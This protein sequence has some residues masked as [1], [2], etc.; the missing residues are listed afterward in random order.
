MTTTALP[1]LV[2][3]LSPGDTDTVHA[4]FAQL[5]PTSVWLRFHTGMPRL[6]P[7]MAARLA[8]VSPGRHE[9]MVAR[10]EGRP[11]GLARW[12]RDPVDPT[13]VEVAVE[14]ADAA[15]GQGIG[16]RLL[17][18]TVAAA[19]SA[20]ARCL[21]AHVHPDNRP[22]VAWLRRLGASH[23]GGLDEPF[24]LSLTPGSES[25]ACGCMK[26]CGSGC[27]DP[28]G[29]RSTPGS[30]HPGDLARAICSLSSWRDVVA[31]SPRRSCSTSSGVRRLWV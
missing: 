13:S 8:A 24:R 14:V 30:R 10:V 11:V 29:S 23:P 17:E 18:E 16:S 22:V 28:S 9:V 19:R 26:E 1:L 2:H 7:A 5:S 6:T 25:A 12:I 4:V 21:V 31:R 3:P 20:G 27:S 15:Q